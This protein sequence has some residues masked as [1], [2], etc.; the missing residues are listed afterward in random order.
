MFSRLSVAL[1]ALGIAS[2]VS[3][4]DDPTQRVQFEPGATSV[5][6]TGTVTGYRSLRYL[7]A[8]RAGQI[9]AISFTPSKKTL[10]FNV[11]QGTH[12][13]HDG[14]SD[15]THAWATK[16]DADGDFVIDVYFKSSDARKNA[17]ATFDLTITVTNPT[18]NYR[19][20]DGR[21]VTVMYVNDPQA[22]RATLVVGGKTYELPQVVSAS[23]ARYSA[24]KVT[25]WNKGR[26]ATLEL[27]GPATQCTE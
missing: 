14:S 23:G 13:L 12:S 15:D 5:D 9:L 22:G 4:A 6:L 10:Y 19:C 24:A 3:A 8:V 1:L 20:A 27:N 7:L 21:N 11:L 25:W 2:A 18:V 16:V 17:Q 26:E